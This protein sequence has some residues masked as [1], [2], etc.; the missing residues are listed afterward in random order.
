MKHDNELK[1][2]EPVKIR[3][4]ALRGGGASLYL[5]IYQGGRRSYEFL[6]L[7]L[8]PE[9][10]KE[11]R[12]A[13]RQTWQLAN[14]VKARR[15]VEMQ[16]DRLGL[17]GPKGSRIRF[18]D[19]FEQR[20]LSRVKE[21]SNKT[22]QLWMRCLKSMKGYEEDHGIT[23]ADITKTWV[24]GFKDYLNKHAGKLANNTRVQYFSKLVACLNDAVRDDII[25]HSPAEGVGKWKMDE[26]E[27]QY[28]TIEELRRMAAT[29]CKNKTLRRAFLFSCLT[30]LRYSDVRGLTWEEVQQGTQGTRITF[31]QRKT[32]GQEYLY[33]TPQA[34]ALMGERAEDDAHVFSGFVSNQATNNG[35]KQ[36]AEAAGIKKHITFHCARHTFAVM[37]LD[38]GTDIYTVSKLLGHRELATTQIYAKVL[39]KNKQ[40]AVERIPDILGKE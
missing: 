18:F 22:Y 20:A 23:F 31:K 37:M 8:V 40:A 14:Q 32:K 6:K 9:K 16:S 11:D 3:Q 35:L 21:Q 1:A 33:I 12:E 24:K 39:D 17:G 13:N 34:A 5:D 28:L 38:I 26:T 29:P 15:I 30:G 10:T 7:Y 4:K 2:K 36:W 19:Y 25:D 27:R